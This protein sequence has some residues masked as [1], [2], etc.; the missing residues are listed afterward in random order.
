[1]VVVYTF[2]L[3]TNIWRSSGIGICL[4][5]DVV[6]CIVHVHG[7]TS[8]YTFMPCKSWN[9]IERQHSPALFFLF[10]FRKHCTELCACTRMCVRAS[11]CIPR[12][13][14][15]ADAHIPVIDT[16][17]CLCLCFIKLFYGKHKYSNAYEARE[18]VVVVII[19]AVLVDIDN[20]RCM[21]VC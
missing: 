6:T 17:K 18:V 1:M 15:L 8:T 16:V 11:I 21:P 7:Y 10:H 2:T 20:S 19:V 3:H 4:D 9:I 12:T 13:F 5:A 14:S